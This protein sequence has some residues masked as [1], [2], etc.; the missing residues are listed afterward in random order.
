[1]KPSSPVV[2]AA[3]FSRLFPSIAADMGVSDIELLLAVMTVI[4]VKTG[5]QII[6]YRGRSDR[7]YLVRQGRLRVWVNADHRPVVLGEIGPGKWV[8]EVTVLDGGPA[9]ATVAAAEESALLALSR[10]SFDKLREQHARI[11][12]RLVLALCRD[13]ANRL[14]RAQLDLGNG[15]S[16]WISSAGL[17]IGAEER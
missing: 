9:T 14:R 10:E 13:L 2:T 15:E 16:G 5:E 6:A 4:T 11:A 8:G 1:M 3:E 17:L 7:L 12:A